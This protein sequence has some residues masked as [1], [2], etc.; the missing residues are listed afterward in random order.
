M[1]KQR[2]YTELYVDLCMFQ[3]RLHYFTFF[4]VLALSAGSHNQCDCAA[5][6]GP[7]CQ[8]KENPNRI[9]KTQKVTTIDGIQLAFQSK[10]V[11]ATRN[12]LHSHRVTLHLE[13]FWWNYGIMSFVSRSHCRRHRTTHISTSFRA[14]FFVFCVCL[15]VWPMSRASASHRNEIMS[16]HNHF[17]IKW[18][19][20]VVVLWATFWCCDIG[21]MSA[22]AHARIHGTETWARD[23]LNN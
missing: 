14:F 23:H 17:W 5:I 12:E 11:L 20:C 21:I 8:A 22:R 15:A 10:W 2:I 9:D 13:W 19:H 6:R 3:R 1:D 18:K 4:F 7:Q 16:N